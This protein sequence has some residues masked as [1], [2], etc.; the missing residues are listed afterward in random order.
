MFAHL[1]TVAKGLFTRQEPEEAHPGSAGASA[2]TNPTMVTA[3]RQRVVAPESA[4]DHTNAVTTNAKRKIQ[5]T[6]TAKTDGQQ[7]KRRKR[8][9]LEAA[10]TTE[11]DVAHDT[12]PKTEHKSSAPPAKSN[13]FRFDSEEPMLP[14]ET[15][16]EE[17]SQ[18][19]NHA[20]DE[21]DDDSDDAPEAI[22]NSAQLLKMKEQ[23]KKQERAQQ[24]EE[25]VKKE[26]RRKMDERRKLQA[27][28]SMKHKET[29]VPDDLLSEST[30]TLQG[31][32]TQDVR[33]RALPALLPDEILNAEPIAR[34]PTPPVEDAV[35]KAKKSNKLRFLD[36]TD[37][38][39]KDVQ[40]GDVSIRVLDTPSSKKKTKTTLPPKASK[41]GRNAK[42]SWLKRD[43]ST[44]QV[45]GLRRTTGGPSGFV[46]R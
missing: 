19:P 12:S 36:K 16:P 9:S 35:I 10:E 33:R 45:N 30:A 2:A 15:H 7:T 22:D 1:V 28:S 8:S 44:A 39:P 21:D 41:A 18:T 27:K 26:K 40:V 4:K 31:S 6:S 3:T 37:K 46:R 29:A 32:T 11:G 43:R 14:E 24:R 42:D 23:A 25:E 17:I 5:S 38:V 20:E 13:H 34:P